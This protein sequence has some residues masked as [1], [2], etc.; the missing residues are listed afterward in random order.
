M[1]GFSSIYCFN[2]RSQSVF[3]GEF[4]QTAFREAV[5]IICTV[6]ANKIGHRGQSDP[7]LGLA[8]PWMAC[9]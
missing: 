9:N 3:S 6:W 5:M 4:A 8:N 2:H 1:H 7:H